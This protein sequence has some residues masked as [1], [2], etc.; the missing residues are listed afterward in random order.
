MLD[1]K[2][3]PLLHNLHGDPRFQALLKRMRL[4]GP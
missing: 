1:V 3:D 4:S 2:T